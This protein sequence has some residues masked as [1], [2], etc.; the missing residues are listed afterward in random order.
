MAQL[1]RDGWPKASLDLNLFA[2]TEYDKANDDWDT[3]RIQEG[4]R[5]RCVPVEVVPAP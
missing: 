3:N 1:V 2:V 4:E 5:Q